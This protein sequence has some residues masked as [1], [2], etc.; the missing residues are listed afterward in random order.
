MS[1]SGEGVN[2]VL[3]GGGAKGSY[4][5]G[6]WRALNEFGVTPNVTHVAGTSVGALNAALFK[7]GD[8]DLAERLWRN[9]RAEDV[10]HAASESTVSSLTQLAA[11]LQLAGIHIAPASIQR[12]ASRGI[13]SRQG[14]RKLSERHI[15][16][17]KVAGPGCRVTG[18]AL[19]SLFETPAIRHFDLSGAAP[20]RCVSV[21]L[22]SSAIP[23]LFPPEIIDGEEHTDGGLPASIGSNTPVDALTG[24]SS[25]ITIVVLQDRNDTFDAQRFPEHRILPIFPQE[26]QGGRLS[27]LDF[28]TAKVQTRIQQGYEDTVRILEPTYRTGRAQLD[29]DRALDVFQ[30]QQQEWRE[31]RRV[32]EQE[33]ARLYEATEQASSTIEKLFP[34]RK[35]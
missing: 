12:I 15:D 28:D 34:S 26:D 32:A 4:Q 16:W 7:Q 5:I 20:E 30:R 14:L 33:Q 1:A 17:P 3:S 18:T 27:G 29:F 21:L 9:L 35:E 11:K 13:F 6:V 19:R 25:P 8:W 22:A 2:L 24:G 23:F 10:L 31:N